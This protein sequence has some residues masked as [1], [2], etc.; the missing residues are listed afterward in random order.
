MGSSSNKQINAFEL[1]ILL[2]KTSGKP[3]ELASRIDLTRLTRLINAH[4]SEVADAA[5]EP[6]IARS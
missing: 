2:A 6:V 3:E 5:I 4:F 1:A